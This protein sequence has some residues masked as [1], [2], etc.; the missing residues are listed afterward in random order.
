M[1]GK[2]FHEIV[3]S[4]IDV[5]IKLKANGEFYIITHEVHQEL[6]LLYFNYRELQDYGHFP[7]KYI[8]AFSL[9]KF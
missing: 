4:Q 5:G 2:L 9:L 1:V 8:L 7:L 3:E 6:L